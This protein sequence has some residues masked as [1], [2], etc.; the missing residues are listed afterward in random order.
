MSRE[1]ILEKLKEIVSASQGGAAADPDAMREDALLVR[2]LG[3]SSVQMLY[4]G[5][6]IEETFHI[7]LEDAAEMN[8]ETVGDAVDMIASKL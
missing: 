7:R 2:D 6:L 4:M 1:E 8:L 3:F 5:V